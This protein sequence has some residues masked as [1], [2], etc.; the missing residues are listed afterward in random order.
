LVLHTSLQASASGG[1]TL[2]GGCMGCKHWKQLPVRLEERDTVKN[3]PH[4]GQKNN[5][6][7][8]EKQWGGPISKKCG[9]KGGGGYQTREREG[10]VQLKRGVIQK[11]NK[12]NTL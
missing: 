7:G 2:K 5:M 8:N 6:G 3:S 9:K 1:A 11:Y 10:F 4:G 12:K